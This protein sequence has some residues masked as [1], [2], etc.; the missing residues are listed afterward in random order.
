MLVHLPSSRRCR[1]K[2]TRWYLGY[3]TLCIDGC[4]LTRIPYRNHGVL[5]GVRMFHRMRVVACD[6]LIWSTP[7]RLNLLEVVA[8]VM[9]QI[10]NL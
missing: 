3:R 2:A 4:V 10:G 1:L 6:G 5:H 9:W 7:A 8:V